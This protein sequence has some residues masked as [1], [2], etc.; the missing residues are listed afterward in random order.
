[1]L[2]I[3]QQFDFT[4]R[5]PIGDQ[6]VAGRGEVVRHTRNDREQISGIGVVFLDLDDRSGKVLD[7]LFQDTE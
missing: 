4:F 6:L 3:G 1:M 7:E 5:S 2:N